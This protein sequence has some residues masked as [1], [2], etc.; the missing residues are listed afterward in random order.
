MCPGEFGSSG[1]VTLTQERYWTVGYP[2]R[3]R[4]ASILREFVRNIVVECVCV[5]VHACGGRGLP[6]LFLRNHPPWFG[7]RV[8]L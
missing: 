8:S 1:L 3:T 6:Q 7:D 5:F 4:R 2:P